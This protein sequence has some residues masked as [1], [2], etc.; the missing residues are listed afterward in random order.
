MPYALL[1]D[2]CRYVLVAKIPV[3]MTHDCTLINP[4]TPFSPPL[5]TC[6]IVVIRQPTER[7]ELGITIND[8]RIPPHRFTTGP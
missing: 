1:H 6:S 3:R 2:M 7:T 8:R 4:P 5:P